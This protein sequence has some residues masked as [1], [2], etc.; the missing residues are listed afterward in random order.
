M[1]HRYW[2]PY[3]RDA[4][5]RTAD[6]RSHRFQVSSHSPDAATVMLFS[7]T[8]WQFGNTVPISGS[9]TKLAN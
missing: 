6:H 9:A 1:T 8:V 4:R 5:K 3:N 7:V 2:F